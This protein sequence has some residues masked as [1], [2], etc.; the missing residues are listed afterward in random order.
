MKK[1]LIFSMFALMGFFSMAQEP[2]ISGETKVTYSTMSNPSN[3]DMNSRIHVTP[4]S[5]VM[6]YGKENK[7]EFS[8]DG[9]QSKQLIVRVVTENL[10]QMRKGEEFG[11]YYFTPLAKEGIVKVRIGEMDFM[12]AYKRIG[13]IEFTLSE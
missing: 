5:L 7:I 4:D 9:V 10:C 3:N 11:Q 13:E 6:V 8:V 2:V 1:L 12:G